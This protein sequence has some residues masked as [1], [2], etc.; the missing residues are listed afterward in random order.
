MEMEMEPWMN[1]WMSES[2]VEWMVW[3]TRVLNGW[4]SLRYHI[5]GQRQWLML[6]NRFGQ[7]N[8]RAEANEC[9]ISGAGQDK[10]NLYPLYCDGLG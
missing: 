1:E 10:G 6:L 7:E 8:G 9:Q 4:L 3:Q 5:T 2:V